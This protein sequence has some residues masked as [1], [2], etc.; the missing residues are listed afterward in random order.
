MAASV[1]SPVSAL[2]GNLNALSSGLGG[3]GADAVVDQYLKGIEAVEGYRQGLIAAPGGAMQLQEVTSWLQIPAIIKALQQDN[4]KIQVTFPDPDRNDPQAAACSAM[5]LEIREFLVSMAGKSFQEILG[6]LEGKISADPYFNSTFSNRMSPAAWI[7]AHDLDG[8]KSNL[9]LAVTDMCEFNESTA[10][11]PNMRGALLVSIRRA[12]LS[13]TS[14]PLVVRL[15]DNT[16]ATV[17]SE[18]KSFMDALP[19]K[20]ASESVKIWLGDHEAV[21]GQ[22]GRVLRKVEEL[23]LDEFLGKFLTSTPCPNKKAGNAQ[24]IDADEDELTSRWEKLNRERKY[25]VGCA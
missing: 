1:A 18:V 20:S 11:D 25:T 8:K 6:Q 4:A 12:V 15:S 14:P 9:S 22:A 2:M 17:A 10:H 13:P 21:F 5:Q 16:A 7:K 3:I 23:S 19:D 24:T